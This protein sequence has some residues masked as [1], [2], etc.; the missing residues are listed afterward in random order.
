MTR[1]K[2]VILVTISVSIVGLSLLLLSF[3]KHNNVVEIK[4][5]PIAI[6]LET[7]PGVY[8]KSQSNNWPM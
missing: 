5:G 6:M 1:L 3:N 4:S 8:T 7:E 2:R